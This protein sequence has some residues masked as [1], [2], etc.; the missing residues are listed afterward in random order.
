MAIASW[1]LACSALS[2]LLFAADKN[3]AQK[4][5]WRTSEKTLLTV[6]LI[7]GWPGAVLARKVL[8]HKTRKAG[9]S[10]KLYLA[11]ICN[12]VALAYFDGFRLFSW[13]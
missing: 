6:A 12:L 2:V 4:G 7:G 9:F 10:V 13:N 11:G 1:Y 3:A 8:R 5:R